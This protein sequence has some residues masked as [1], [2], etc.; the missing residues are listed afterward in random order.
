MSYG[1]HFITK[2]PNTVCI[3]YYTFSWSEPETVKGYVKRFLT[4]CIGE[5]LFRKYVNKMRS[6]LYLRND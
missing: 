4:K 5:K 6:I 1:T 2:T 3:H